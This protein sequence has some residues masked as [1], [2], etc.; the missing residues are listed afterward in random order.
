MY[1]LLTPLASVRLS[2]HFT[3]KITTM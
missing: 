3:T 1:N 2:K